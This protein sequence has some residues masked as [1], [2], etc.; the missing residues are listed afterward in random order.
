MVG[1]VISGIG[2]NAVSAG[3]GVDDARGIERDQ[4]GVRNIVP[5]SERCCGPP[6]GA[7]AVRR[8]SRT[9]R[10][11]RTR[12]KL[13]RGR[14]RKRIFDATSMPV[15]RKGKSRQEQAIESTR[16]SETWLSKSGVGTDHDRIPPQVLSPAK[17]RSTRNKARARRRS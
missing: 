16:R 5:R 1:E 10:R 11:V 4:S 9:S 3:C 15:V 8:G 14:S 2:A 6:T 12:R 7:P 17:E 13:P